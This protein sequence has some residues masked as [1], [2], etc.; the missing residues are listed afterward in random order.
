MEKEFM[1]A[2]DEH[3]DAIFRF[4]FL[5]VSEIALA[6]DMT[7]ETFMRYWQALRRGQE[8]T[9][10]RSFL[11]TIAGNLAKDWYK[12]KKSDSLDYKME[13]GFEPRERETRNA[14]I[15]AEYQEAITKISALGERDREVLFLRYTEGLD[16]KDI[17]DILGE[18]ANAV[19]V[20]LSRAMKHL[21]KELG[22]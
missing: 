11:Y 22:V 1:Q 21:Q 16:P 9:N 17:A 12:K 14:Q 3:G 20:R 19:S 4:C 13:Q 2:F 5:K 8:M 15:L 10:T 7:Q 18:S 6:E